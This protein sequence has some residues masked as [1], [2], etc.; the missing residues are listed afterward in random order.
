VTVVAE[1]ANLSAGVLSVR[2]FA[3]CRLNLKFRWWM[4]WLLHPYHHFL[5]CLHRSH[6]LH[7]VESIAAAAHPS[8]EIADWGGMGTTE[9][10]VNVTVVAE[11][12]NL[13]AGVLSVRIFAKCRLNLKFRLWMFWLLHPYRHFLLCRHKVSGECAS[14]SEIETRIPC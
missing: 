8:S 13:S 5:F 7:E 3:K 9:W 1:T 11:T 6:R 2:I 4:F 14:N 10:R 12:A